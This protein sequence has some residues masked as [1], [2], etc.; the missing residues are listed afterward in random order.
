MNLLIPFNSYEPADI[1]VKQKASHKTATSTM[2][3]IQ[4]LTP[5]IV[6][7]WTFSKGDLRVSEIIKTFIIKHARGSRA[8]F[9]VF[10][11]LVGFL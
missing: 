8:G 1:R 6:R 7:N 5:H 2:R 3:N 11:Y 4:R 10:I 9:S